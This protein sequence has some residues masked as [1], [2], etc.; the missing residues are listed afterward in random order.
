VTL[1]ARGPTAE[2]LALAGRAR[3]LRDAG[4]LQR[5]IQAALGVSRSYAAELLSDPDGSKA[6]A[7]MD[8]YRGVCADCGGPTTGSEGPSA[9]PE[10]CNAC[11]RALQHAEAKWTRETVID[12]IRRF[13]AMHG[14]PPLADEWIHA[15]P[16]NGYPP[17]SAV[18]GNGGKGKGAWHQP[19]AR[20]AD[21]IEAAGFER[22]RR[23]QYVR[24]PRRAVVPPKYVQTT[25][26]AKQVRDYIILELDD[27]GRWIQHDPV[28]SYSEAL[29]IEKY[30][31]SLGDMNGRAGHKFVAV[32]G[33]RWIVRELQTVTSFKAVA[34]TA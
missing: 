2:R 13:A 24:R 25:E 20:W 32:S 33:A 26:G 29:A 19:F 4:V 16:V 27:D 15:D 22:P 9:T 23:G 18:Y 14:R 8:G 12:A 3:E 7:R 1:A 6:R 17:R 5:E 28:Q 21:A 34:A 10:R 31:E 11:A 30:V